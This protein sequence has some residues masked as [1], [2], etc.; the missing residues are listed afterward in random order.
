[1]FLF[2][3]KRQ[4]LINLIREIAKEEI[5]L[6][7]HWDLWAKEE[8]HLSHVEKEILHI[9]LQL[10]HKKKIFF[11][12]DRSDADA[13][14]LFELLEDF[15]KDIVRLKEGYEQLTQAD[16]EHVDSVN[17]RLDLIL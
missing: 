13:Q 14:R 11:K 8:K 4:E 5:K 16:K 2:K 6:G 15:R 1:M 17:R 7:N 10:M 9:L 12:Q 3:D